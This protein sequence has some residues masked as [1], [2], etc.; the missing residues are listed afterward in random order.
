[1]KSNYDGFSLVALLMGVVVLGVVGA[2]GLYIY[3]SQKSSDK[4]SNSTSEP[5]NTENADAESR[6]SATSSEQEP[7]SKTVSMDDWKTLSIETASI[8]YPSTLAPQGTCSDGQGLLGII[9]NSDSFNYECN[10]AS[11][12]LSYASI[13]FGA[14]SKSVIDTINGNTTG[15]S[16][17][18]IAGD[19]TATKYVFTN[20]EK[21]NDYRYVVYEYE[22]D[23][24]FSYAI[25][26]TG[27]GFSDEDEFLNDFTAVVENGWTIK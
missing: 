16:K 12:A 13:V 22:Q 6:D 11:Q 17:V 3:N 7:L 5:A 1:M 4:V 8:K 15:S 23:D 21:E 26:K 19:L 2:A 14:G 27:V 18:N 20:T 10:G 24:K 9:Y 25:Y